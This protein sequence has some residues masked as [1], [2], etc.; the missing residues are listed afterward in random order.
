MPSDNAH[1]F[2]NVG[3]DINS[4]ENWSAALKTL[5]PRVLKRLVDAHKCGLLLSRRSLARMLFRCSRAC[6]AP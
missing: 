5:K 6:K 1:T 4:A 2:D 3:P